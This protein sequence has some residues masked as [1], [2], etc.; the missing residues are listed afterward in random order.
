MSSQERVLKFAIQEL[1]K[2]LKSAKLGEEITMPTSLQKIASELEAVQNP[3]SLKEADIEALANKLSQ[4]IDKL[5][6]S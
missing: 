2:A 4:E 3:G 1:T 5:E 6:Q